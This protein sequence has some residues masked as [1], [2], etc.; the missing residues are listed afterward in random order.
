MNITT[1]SRVPTQ[2]NPPP[3]QSMAALRF[4]SNIKNCKGY[5]YSLT[6]N[7]SKI[8]KISTDENLITNNIVLYKDVK[9]FKYQTF[10]RGDHVSFLKN[11][12]QIFICNI[13]GTHFG[14]TSQ[15]CLKKIPLLIK[16]IYLQ[17][18]L[19]LPVCDR[20]NY[21]SCDRGISYGVSYDIP[22][23]TSLNGP[24]ALPFLDSSFAM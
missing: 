4:F 9:Y 6:E 18:N 7:Q 2:H 1:P 16:E 5:D 24:L 10:G 23:K 19:L 8:Y 12:I 21:R 15:S 14:I 13:Y 22:W 3:T 11:T 20:C 17:L